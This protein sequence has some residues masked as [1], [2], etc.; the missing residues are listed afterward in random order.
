MRTRPPKRPTRRKA[1]PRRTTRKRLRLTLAGPKRRYLLIAG[2]VAA[3]FGLILL[4]TAAVFWQ[5]YG[6]IIDARLGGAQ[7]ESPRVFGRPFALT[8]GRGL[9]PDQLVQ[10]LN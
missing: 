1:A 3:A 7:Q 9:S 2:G 8:P 5:S 10:R 4:I 6:R